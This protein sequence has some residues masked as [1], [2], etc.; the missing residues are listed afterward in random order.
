[1][2]R[3]VPSRVR[4]GSALGRDRGRLLRFHALP[5]TA[6]QM[7]AFRFRSYQSK[8]LTPDDDD[9]MNPGHKAL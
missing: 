8:L 5:R 1:L 4:K 9:Q 3:E 2:G 7:I 6:I